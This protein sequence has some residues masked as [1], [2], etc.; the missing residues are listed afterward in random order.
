[1][2]AL[3]DPPRF[4]NMPQP[5]PAPATAEVP[6]LIVASCAR[7]RFRARRQMNKRPTST[8]VPRT[9]QTTAT[10][11]RTTGLDS[12]SSETGRVAVAVL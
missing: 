4:V 5:P 3:G 1:M 10:T 8:S 2:T 12:E 9:E 11:V 7:R 6:A